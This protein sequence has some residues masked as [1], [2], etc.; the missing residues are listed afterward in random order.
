MNYYTTT[1]YCA[2]LHGTAQ[3][4]TVLH[5]TGAWW[6][7]LPCRTVHCRGMSRAPPWCSPCTTM[8]LTDLVWVLCSG[9]IRLGNSRLT[10]KIVG[11]T[12]SV[13]DRDTPTLPRQARHATARHG[14]FPGP[15]CFYVA[16]EEIVSPNFLLEQTIHYPKNILAEEED[17]D[18]LKSTVTAEVQSN[19][20]LILY[21]GSARCRQTWLDFF[22]Q[23]VLVSMQAAALA[24]PYQTYCATVDAS[25]PLHASFGTA[26]VA[27]LV[28]IK[29]AKDR[30]KGDTATTKE[31]IKLGEANSNR[32]RGTDNF[33]K[34]TPTKEERKKGKVSGSGAPDIDLHAVN[35][36]RF[37]QNPFTVSKDLSSAAVDA[38]PQLRVPDFD[39][40]SFE[41]KLLFPHLVMEYKRDDTAN[42][43]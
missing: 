11:A 3:Y 2:A 6:R 26:N 12:V 31:E 37:L 40:T 43:Y 8:Q 32:S 25:P 39:A 14:F 10:G 36:K 1:R 15:F 16:N 9:Y 41:G 22:T 33:K 24:P 27:A 38:V 5:G 29:Y 35:R 7:A 34:E 4:C 30:L 21:K 17:M 13:F 20:L 18:T 19:I 28:L 23:A 42:R